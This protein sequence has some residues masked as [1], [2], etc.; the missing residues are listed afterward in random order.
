MDSDA[1]WL[2]IVAGLIFLVWLFHLY[3]AFRLWRR[4]RSWRSFR[5]LFIAVMLQL[6]LFRIWLGATRLAA[7]DDP[8][9]EAAHLV[10]SPLLS[11]L[12]LSGGFVV[13]FAWTQDR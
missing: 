12:L 8:I 5:N 4:E 13:A 2:S 6:G 9:L 11:L 1:L 10:T 3:R 7:P